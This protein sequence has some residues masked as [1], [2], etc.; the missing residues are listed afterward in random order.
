MHVLTLTLKSKEKK[1]EEQ[2]TFPHVHTADLLLFF[3]EEYNS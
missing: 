2:I 3:S 1:E